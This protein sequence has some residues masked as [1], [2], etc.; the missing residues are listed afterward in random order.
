[1]GLNETALAD[2]MIRHQQADQAAADE[3]VKRLSPLLLRFL[4]RA[5]YRRRHCEDLLQECW[6]R[7]HKAH[8]TY[9]PGT[10]VL[11]W[12][13]PIARHTRVDVYRHYR[14]IE[15]GHIRMIAVSASLGFLSD[16]SRCRYS[17]Q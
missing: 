6:I 2:L 3:L 4:S 8:H 17:P 5:I 7:I 16:S 9:R 10:P 13:Y 11:P 14:R 15:I 12:I 1:V